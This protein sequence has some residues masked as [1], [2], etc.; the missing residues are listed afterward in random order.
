MIKIKLLEHDDGIFDD[1]T[2]KIVEVTDFPLDYEYWISLKPIYEILNSEQIFFLFGQNVT[3][4]I[5]ENILMNNF[6]K[7]TNGR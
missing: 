5:E 4:E 6:K 7:V 1:Y 3:I 2:V